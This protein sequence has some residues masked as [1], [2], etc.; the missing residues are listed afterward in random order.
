[1]SPAVCVDFGA[2]WGLHTP[3]RG[4]AGTSAHTMCSPAGVAGL[5]IFFVFVS[6]RQIFVASGLF[7][8]VASRAYSGCGVSH[9]GDFS[10]RRAQA[11]GVRAQSLLLHG[12]WDPPGPGIKPASPALASRFF[13]PEPPGKAWPL[14][15]RE[16]RNPGFP[17]NSS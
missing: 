10:C 6:L 2:S 11:L 15:L 5:L 16:G 8:C 1:M 13:T 12:K 7:S 4:A 14:I 17:L 9:G 3:A